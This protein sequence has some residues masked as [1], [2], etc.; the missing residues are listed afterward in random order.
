MS[1]F[2]TDLQQYKGHT[3]LTGD[4]PTGRLHLG[5][6]IGS[7]RARVAL[8]HT[9]S[10]FVIIADQ[11]ALTD[12][13]DNPGRVR[14]NVLEVVLDYLAVGIDPSVTTIFLQS[15]VPQITELFLYYL[16]LIPYSR[17]E[18][19][20]TVKTEIAQKGMG[21]SVPAGFVCYPAHQVGDIT[22]FGATLV[23][24]GR[25]QLP[26][27]ELT[28]DVVDK[29]NLTYGRGNEVLTRCQALIPKI[30]VLPGL[31][32]NAKMGKTTGNALFLADSPSEIDKKIKGAKSD[33]GHLK[34]ED[35][36]N[37]ENSTVFQYLRAFD[38]DE[39]GLLELEARYRGGGVSD[40]AV[41]ERLRTVLH[42]LLTPIRKRREGFASDPAEVLRIIK[43]GTQRAEERAAQTLHRVKAAMGINYFE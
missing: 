23:P 13:A 8:Q 35:P 16:N 40:G 19:N 24:V 27:I 33:P 21:D 11:Q 10:Q 12:N 1:E 18:R 2:L 22:A 3:I 34:I 43:A 15:G 37:P 4:R 5:H 7:L 29:F 17:L 30:G 14:E 9:N 39:S 26:M 6:Y 28:N 20:P 32:G 38:P 42:D 25:D 31:D 36:G 41:K